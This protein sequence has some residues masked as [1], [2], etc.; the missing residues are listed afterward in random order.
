MQRA[1]IARALAFSPEIILADEPTG[2]LDNVTT[3]EIVK[4]LQ[5]I[6]NRGT[7]VIMATHDMTIV[8]G[9][10]KRTI[11]LDKGRLVKDEKRE[12]KNK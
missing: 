2:N 11:T 1:A 3:W 7:T 12:K 10:P 5:D 9:L 4:L 6:N 8:N